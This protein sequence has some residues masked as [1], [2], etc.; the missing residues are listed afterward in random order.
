MSADTAPSTPATGQ[1]GERGLVLLS[2]TL[3][4]GAIAA[5]L[6]TTIVTIALHALRRELGATVSLI[7]WVTTAYVLAMAAVILPT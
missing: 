1:A 4:V 3:M 6:D 2:A 5:L 7:Q